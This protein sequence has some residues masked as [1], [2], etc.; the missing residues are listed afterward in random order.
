MCDARHQR[1]VG[2]LSARLSCAAI[3]HAVCHMLTYSGACSPAIFSKPSITARNFHRHS[4]SSSD[5][6]SRSLED[7]WLRGF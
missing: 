2:Q 7:E 3:A 6:R 5:R 1:A 4:V